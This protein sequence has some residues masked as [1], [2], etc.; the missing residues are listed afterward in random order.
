[1][2]I[3][4]DWHIHTHCSCDSACLTFEDLI[5]D[6]RELGIT[7]FGVSDHYHTSLQTH[8]IE[9]SRAE[10]ESALEMHPELKGHFHFGVEATVVSEWEIDR[11]KRGVKENLTSCG[12]LVGGPEVA[13]IAFDFDDAFIEKYKI[14]YVVA[15]MHWPKYGNADT[16]SLIKEYHRQYMFCATNPHSTILA[17][18]LWWDEGLYSY[19]WKK[20][21]FKNPFLDF[22]VITESMRDEL[23]CALKENNVAFE[24]NPC[25][26]FKNMPQAF[27]DAYLGWASDLQRDGVV[28]S[29][30]SDCHKAHITNTDY[31]K[32][33]KIFAHY[34]IDSDKFFCL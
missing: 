31:G 33:D 26:F 3:K 8:D 18:Y 9:L 16:D 24:L 29:F 11:I 4:S 17:H 15:A 22:S 28:L 12:V 20:T 27:A 5:K 13:S 2:A 32:I 1:M 7:D 14:D 34:G 30:G 19:F 21:D 10:Y 25:M 6:A 23:K